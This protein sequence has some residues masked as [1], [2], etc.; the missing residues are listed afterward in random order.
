MP[1]IF[2]SL[3]FSETVTFINHLI[4]ITVRS[5]LIFLTVSR[6]HE[7]RVCCFIWV[8]KLYLLF[9]EGRQLPKVE[10]LWTWL[11]SWN[12]FFLS[13]R[14]IVHKNDHIENTVKTFL[15]DFPGNRIRL[16]FQRG[17]WTRVSFRGDQAG[18][19]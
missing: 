4:L 6:K 1:L 13:N 9:F 19:F 3:G 16:Q 17:T 8:A 14:I 2:I 12:S 7:S 18:G 10:N 11:F 15:T 5:S